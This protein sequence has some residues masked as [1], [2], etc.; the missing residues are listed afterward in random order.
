[1]PA[2]AADGDGNDPLWDYDAHR[3]HLLVALWYES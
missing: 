3:L 1:M 2:Y